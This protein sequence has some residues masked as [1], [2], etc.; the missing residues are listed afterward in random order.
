MIVELLS[1]AHEMAS[2]PLRGQPMEALFL[3]VVKVKLNVPVK[4]RLI[5][6]SSH[7]KGQN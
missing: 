4:G 1:V 3:V 6:N 7:Q 2:E 5:K